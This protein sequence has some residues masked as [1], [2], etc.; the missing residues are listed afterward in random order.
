MLMSQVT[1]KIGK[2]DSK[3]KKILKHKFQEDKT[4]YNFKHNIL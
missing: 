4:F 2:G 3:K 1:S